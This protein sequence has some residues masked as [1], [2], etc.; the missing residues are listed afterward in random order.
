[1][2]QYFAA[3]ARADLD[4]LPIGVSGSEGEPSKGCERG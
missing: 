4:D 1:M 2:E 3:V